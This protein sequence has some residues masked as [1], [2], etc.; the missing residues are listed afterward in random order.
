MP[1]SGGDIDERATWN[2]VNG[3]GQLTVDIVKVFLEMST[4]AN[5]RLGRVPMPMDGEHSSRFYCIKHSL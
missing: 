3:V 5:N 2:H 4:E 1:L